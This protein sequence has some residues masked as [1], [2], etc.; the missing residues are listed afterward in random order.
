M[1]WA[2]FCDATLDPFLSFLSLSLPLSSP[3]S[4]PQVGQEIEVRPGI[5]SKT[6]D[7]KIKCK[8]IL[9]K[10][11]SL[12]AEQNQLQFAVPGGLIG[13]YTH[14]LYAPP[15]LFSSLLS[16]PHLPSSLLPYHATHTCTFHLDW[17][18][19]YQPLTDAFPRPPHH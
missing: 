1:Q 18:W 10:I 12:F 19:G 17:G 15:L 6:A 2:L 14:N 13:Q 9:S 11:I 4:P 8:P 5:V 16:P 7:G 3:P